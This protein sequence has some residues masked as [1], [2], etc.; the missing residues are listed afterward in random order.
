MSPVITVQILGAG[1]YPSV[2]GSPP[3]GIW[4][5]DT[6]LTLGIVLSGCLG[7][8]LS[9]A[10]QNHHTWTSGAGRHPQLWGSS[11]VGI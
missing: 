3:V 9:L 2:W 10:P 5:W 7:L 1:R 11:C 8:E 6:S 4:Y